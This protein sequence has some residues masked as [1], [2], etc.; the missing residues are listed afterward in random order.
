MRKIITNRHI[1]ALMALLFTLPFL[2]L[3]AIVSNRIEPFI[4]VIRPGPDTS[5]LEIGLLIIVLLLLP[6]GAYIAARPMFQKTADGK[7]KLYLVNG[8]IALS[9]LLAFILL[10]SGILSEFYRCDILL[11]PNCD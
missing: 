5:M 3:N 1:S 9:L 7:V 6:T 10:V 4:S 11:I 8:I 2:F